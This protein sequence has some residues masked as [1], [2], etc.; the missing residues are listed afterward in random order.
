MNRLS[1]FSRY[2]KRLLP[3]LYIGLALWMETLVL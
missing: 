3:M 2:D 1:R